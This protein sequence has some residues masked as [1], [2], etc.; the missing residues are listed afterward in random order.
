M[1]NVPTLDLSVLPIEYQNNWHIYLILREDSRINYCLNVA[2]AISSDQ[3]NESWINAFDAASRDWFEANPMDDIW[4]GNWPEG[5]A[6]FLGN[7][8]TAHA[9]KI[10]EN[11]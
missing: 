11:T 9:R 4:D 2:N 8:A 6:V 10:I 7:E 3:N 1:K 5:S